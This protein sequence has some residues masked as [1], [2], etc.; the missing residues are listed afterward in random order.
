MYIRVFS[1][2][3]ETFFSRFALGLHQ[4]VV[5][6]QYI[7]L[8]KHLNIFSCIQI[9]NLESLFHNLLSVFVRF[10]K[11]G[12]ILYGLMSL[13]FYLKRRNASKTH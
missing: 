5:C 1:E 9:F 3:F 6:I 4:N 7:P 11:F 10:C 13:V 2:F 12:D 8:K